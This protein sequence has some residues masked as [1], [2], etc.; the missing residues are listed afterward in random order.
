[1]HE[2][3]SIKSKKI[4]CVENHEE[5]KVNNEIHDDRTF[6]KKMLLLTWLPQIAREYI[7]VSYHFLLRFLFAYVVYLIGSTVYSDIRTTSLT[8][9]RIEQSKIDRCYDDFHV[10]NCHLTVVPALKDYC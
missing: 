4:A 10:N 1:M 6:M 7:N 2:E 5:T 3:I 8:T 9:I